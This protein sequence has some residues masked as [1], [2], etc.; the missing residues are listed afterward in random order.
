[1]DWLYKVTGKKQN[2]KKK[3]T[4]NTSNNS[5]K[6]NFGKYFSHNNPTT[7]FKTSELN[8]DFQMAIVS[9]EY[10]MKDHKKEYTTTI[11][12]CPHCN[13]SKNYSTTT[14]IIEQSSYKCYSCNKYSGLF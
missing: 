5:Y 3:I 13:E 7:V 12:K 14:D 10:I 11:I 4:G 8:Y 6:A 2:R 9:S 1:M